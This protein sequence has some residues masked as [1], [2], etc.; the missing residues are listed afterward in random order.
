MDDNQNNVSQ[1]A[2]KYVNKY[3]KNRKVQVDEI[4]QQHAGKEECDVPPNDEFVAINGDAV[5]VFSHIGKREYQQDAV[6]VSDNI[7][8]SSKGKIWMGILCDG[9]GGMNGGERAS[10]LCVN[11]MIEKYK[12]IT[13]TTDIPYFLRDCVIELDEAVYDLKDEFGNN[14]GAGSTMI[15]IVVKNNMLY[16]ASVGDSHLYVLRGNSLVLLNEEHNY[17][18]DLM[19]QVRKGNLTI[20]EAYS[21]PHKEALTSFMGVGG[22]D[23]IDIKSA[24]LEKGDCVI[25]TSDGLYRSLNHTEIAQITQANINS[26]TNA[27][28]TLVTAAVSK[29]SPHQDNT[30]VIAIRI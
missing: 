19:V 17:L 1:A 22:V 13:D 3:L 16:W 27:S 20:E 28:R 25:L 9:M 5:G 18:A 7:G 29:G 14:L 15:S 21:D 2:G 8:P 4:I 26:M 6:A 23:R 30:S 11:A 12:S 10:A 24:Q